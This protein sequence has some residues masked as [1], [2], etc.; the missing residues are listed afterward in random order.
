MHHD[1]DAERADMG[2]DND[3]DSNP[4]IENRGRMIT[5]DTGTRGTS[6]PDQDRMQ[7]REEE[8]QARKTSTETGE[9]RLGKD[10]V[11]EQRSVEVPVTREEVY[12]ER[13]PVDRRP[14][15]R[16]ISD[17]EH[18]SIEVPVREE[19]VSVE[20]KPVVYEEVGVG[21]RQ[22]EEARDVNATVRRE[23]LRVQHEGDVR[24]SGGTDEYRQYVGEWRS[25]PGYRGRAWTDVQGEVERDW[26]TRHPDMSWATA[27]E[28]IRTAW[29]DRSD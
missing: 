17:S 18:A 27:R 12:V 7:L 29:E 28:R 15:D 23:E 8:L 19:R 20:K 2:L 10:V 22:V 25:R 24:M 6:T 11:T 21:K 1:D 16:P 3:R 14:S 9:V 13:E 26:S 5:S 4:L